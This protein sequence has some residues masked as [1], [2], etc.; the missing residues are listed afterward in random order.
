MPPHSTTVPITLELIKTACSNCNL[1]EICLPLGLNELELAKLDEARIDAERSRL[2][3]ECRSVEA[4]YNDAQRKNQ[5]LASSQFVRKDS[6]E[7]SQNRLGQLERNRKVL[8]LA[9]EESRKQLAKSREVTRELKGLGD[10]AG[11]AVQATIIAHPGVV[12]RLADVEPET[13]NE[14]RLRYRLGT[15]AA[16]PSATD[17]P[18]T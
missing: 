1:R 2:V 7:E 17:Q 10:N 3:F 8:S 9:S 11:A 15:T 4:D 5:R 13:L 6:R 16:G 18:P 12:A 14:P